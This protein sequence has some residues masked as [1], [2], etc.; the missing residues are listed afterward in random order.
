M[1]FLEARLAEDAA[2]RDEIHA[3]NCTSLRFLPLPCDCPGPARALR[4]LEAKARIVDEHAPVHP[5][6][7]RE[8]VSSSQEGLVILSF[9]PVCDSEEPPCSTLRALT[10][11]YSDHPDYRQEWTL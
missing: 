11:V 5:V 1:E 8:L 7:L 3:R 9:C 4:E 10:S 6:V 2:N